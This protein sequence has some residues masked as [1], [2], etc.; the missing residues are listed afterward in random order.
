[1]HSHPSNRM[2]SGR[3]SVDCTVQQINWFRNGLIRFIVVILFSGFHWN[4]VVR[5]LSCLRPWTVNILNV[6]LVCHICSI[7]ANPSD[8]TPLRLLFYITLWRGG[9]W[10]FE[11]VLHFRK[12]KKRNHLQLTTCVYDSWILFNDPHHCGTL[13]IKTHECVLFDIWRVL[14]KKHIKRETWH[15]TNRIWATEPNKR[16]ASKS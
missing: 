16:M 9:S 14:H 15:P 1:M 12:A 11:I 6:L 5:V 10:V 13:N 8:F 2:F 4:C 7:V 3:I